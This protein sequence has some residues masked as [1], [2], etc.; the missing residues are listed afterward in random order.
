AFHE[1]SS[2]SYGQSWLAVQVFV[3]VLVEEGHGNPGTVI[4]RPRRAHEPVG[5]HAP[6]P[7]TGPHGPGDDPPVLVVVRVGFGWFGFDVLEPGRIG[8]PHPLDRR[9]HAMDLRHR[10][11]P[12]L[13]VGARE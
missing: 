7:V 10:L 1:P 5:G 8:V 11:G 12:G 13:R 9:T 6:E 4:A 3:H 2:L